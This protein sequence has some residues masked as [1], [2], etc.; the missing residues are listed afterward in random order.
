MNIRQQWTKFSSILESGGSQG[1]VLERTSV[2][3]KEEV[4]T[5]DPSYK[6]ETD[7]RHGEQICGCQGR[8]G[9]VWDGWGVLGWQM[10]TV[11]FGMDGQWGPTVQHRELCVIGSLCYI[12]EIDETL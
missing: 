6:T 12:M 4:H 1:L 8:E 11:T 5:D 10:Q 2:Q 9:R 7:H 3:L